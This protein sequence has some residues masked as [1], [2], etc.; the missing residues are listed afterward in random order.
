[1]FFT[2]TRNNGIGREDIFISK[3]IDGK[4]ESPTPLP[5][6]IN[7]AFFEFNAYVNPE[8][9]L[10]IF[11]SFGREDGLGGGDLYISRKDDQGNWTKSKNLGSRI[12]SDKLDYC[13]FIDWR[14]RKFY[15]T[16]ERNS[17][18][19][20]RLDKIGQLKQLANRP[21]NGFGN[22]YTIGFDT[23]D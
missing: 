2:A 18:D 4:Y 8:E 16:S 22:I 17:I 15:F 3:F 20:K 1:L 23:L 6:E 21:L 19:D 14:T 5:K 9:N 12:N 11:S 7:S 13:P 10:L